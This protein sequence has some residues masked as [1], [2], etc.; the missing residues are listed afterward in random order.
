MNADRTAALI[1]ALEARLRLATL[2]NDASV[3]DELKTDDWLNINPDGR[4]TT[5]Q[6]LLDLI[7]TFDFH[8]IDDENVE[9]R[10][11][12]RTAVVTGASTRV[13]ELGPDQVKTSRVVFTRVY[14]LFDSGWRL[15]STQATPIE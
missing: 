14:A 8:S 9:I 4:V 15:V 12:P 1:R 7:S 5:K 10:I 13:L 6:D 11:Y 2:E 3:I